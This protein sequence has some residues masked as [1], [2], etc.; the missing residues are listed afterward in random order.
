MSDEQKCERCGG[1]LE[2]A[3]GLCPECDERAPKWLLWTVYGLIFLF[4][5]GLIYRLIWP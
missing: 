5:V 2:K 4:V 1:D 3:S